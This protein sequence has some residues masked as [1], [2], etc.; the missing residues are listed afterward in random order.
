MEFLSESTVELV[1]AS[2]S[3]AMVVKA[4][5]VSTK[6]MGSKDETSDEK[7]IQYLVRNKHESPLEHGSLTF[8]IHTPIFVAREFMRH[9]T[10]SYNE[11]SAR[12]RKL[13]PV[14]WLPGNGRALV[15]EGKPGH[16]TFTQGSLEQMQKTHGEM[17]EAYS[18]AYDSYLHML[19]AGVCREVARTVLPFGIFTSFY[20]TANPR[21]VLKFLDL[22]MDP[23]A[24]LEIQEVATCIYEHLR[25][26]MP[27]TVAAWFENTQME[28]KGV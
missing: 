19:S 5:R 26:M 3:D 15:Q 1:D 13:E 24:Q 9:R 25:G 28:T 21:N 23:H 18:L 14:F 27:I 4:A 22:R 16:Y 2:C 10:W 6:G 20:A 7:L 17:K 12:Y 11:E 8:R